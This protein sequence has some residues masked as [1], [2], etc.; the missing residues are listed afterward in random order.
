MWRNI[1]LAGILLTLIFAPLVT[2]LTEIYAQEKGMASNKIETVLSP[3]RTPLVSFRILFLTGAADD[4]KG[5]EGV[6]ALTAAML[7]KGGS[8]ERSYDQIVDAMYPMAASL[9]WQS[10]KEMTVFS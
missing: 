8:R 5:K 1:S 6:A 10:D 7:A 3:N 4:P 2:T 9:D